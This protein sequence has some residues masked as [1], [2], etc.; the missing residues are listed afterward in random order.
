MTT[1]DTF[2]TL[3]EIEAKEIDWLW[4]SLIPYEKT[5]I[6]EG[7]PEL[8]KSYLCMHIAAL[9]STGGKLPDGTRVDKGNVLYISSED[10]AA[11]T[12]RPRMEQMGADLA[13][14]RVLDD[15]L[16]FDDKGLRRLRDEM[17]DHTPD[18][19]VVDTLYSFLSDK[20]DLGK[21]TSIRAGLHKLDRLFKEFGPAV[22]VIR[23]WTKGSKGKA[24]YRGVGAIDV[25]GVVRTTL[26]VAAHPDD[27]KLR[28]LAQVKNN[29]GAKPQGFVYEIVPQ[30]KG[31]P[32][33]EWRGRTDYS[34]NDLE[35]QG[36]DG[37]SEFSRAIEF[38][39]RV[40]ATGPMA[41][42]DLFERADKE[43]I[44]RPTLNRAKSEAGVVSEK[45]GKGWTWRLDET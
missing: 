32:V 21:P 37:R 15:F 23:H 17:E 45:K 38:L 28:I 40:L 10:D 7:D 13:R 6:L 22:V 42:A 44:S 19:V 5:T 26:A 3:A 35:S 2:R 25:V 14:V 4:P 31:L 11:D 12:I 20:V 36:Q 18:L 27:E 39:E 8:G 1:D 29:I 43:G 9:V 24:I 30:E 41:S 34:A 16:V 33:I